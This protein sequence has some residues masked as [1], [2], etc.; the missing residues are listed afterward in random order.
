MNILNGMNTVI[1][2]GNAYAIRHEKETYYICKLS[3]I[4]K[5][6]EDRSARAYNRMKDLSM[7]EL[8]IL[9]SSGNNSIEIES[10]STS[11]SCFEKPEEFIVSCGLAQGPCFEQA[12]SEAK[13]MNL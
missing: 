12:L 2:D 13:E 3:F 4:A 8:L 7:E 1:L 6:K 5:G 9:T 10:Q 11:I